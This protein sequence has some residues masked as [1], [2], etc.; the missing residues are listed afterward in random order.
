MYR[1]VLADDSRTIH[2]VVRH[3]FP[4]DQLDSFEEGR[5]A[6][7]H[8]QRWGAD[9]VLADVALPELDGYELCRR[10][11]Q[12]DRTSAIPV[13]LLA[14]SLQPLDLSRFGA[15]R[16]DGVL[17]KP[18]ETTE[19][20]SLVERLVTG[21]AETSPLDAP[22]APE[23][24]F[25]EREGA[26]DAERPGMLFGLSRSACRPDFEILSVRTWAAPPKAAV[27]L[28]EEQFSAIVEAV[29]RDVLG[30]LRRIL[31]EVARQVLRP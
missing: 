1:L 8:I 20:V 22:D 4:A 31:P 26:G 14:G 23:P 27:G 11:R 28:T 15:V 12:D 18:F 17:T 7:D 30:N 16:P 19:L 25:D 24:D 9:L 21:R 2:K 5:S 10:I 29:S 13:V 6:F 3:S